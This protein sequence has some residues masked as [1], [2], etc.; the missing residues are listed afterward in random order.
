MLLFQFFFDFIGSIDDDF[1][2]IF[3]AHAQ[4]LLFVNF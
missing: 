3:T 4:K 1:G 2:L